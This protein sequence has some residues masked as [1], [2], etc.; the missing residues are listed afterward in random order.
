MNNQICFAACMLLLGC[1]DPGKIKP[2]NR[3]HTTS[4]SKA[5]I[6]KST[7]PIHYSDREL[8]AFLDSIGKL[9]T[10]PLVDKVAFYAD[11]VFLNQLPTSKTLSP[12]QFDL[13]QQAARTSV[14]SISSAQRIF[15]DVAIDSICNA[16]RIDLTYQKGLVPVVYYPFNREGFDEFALCIGDPEHCPNAVLYFFKGNKIIAKH[17]G[18][19][20]FFGLDLKHYKDSDGRTVV[21]YVHEFTEGSGVWWN[22]YFFYKYDGDTLLPILNELQ[23]GNLQSPWGFRIFWLES[24]IQKENPLTIKMVYYVQLPDT[25]KPDLGSRIIDDSTLVRYE[26]S[27][28]TKK[29]VARYQNSKITGSQVLS[30]Y[31][32]DNDLLFIN[33]YYKTLKKALRDTGQKRAT[34]NFLNEEKNYYRD[35]Q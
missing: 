14:I 17:D 25:T 3:N 7:N 11:S 29:L 16:S 13:V 23:N 20:R 2:I 31:V 10:Q 28:P 1:K 35:H 24:T 15:P 12:E 5:A 19:S 27:E 6:E 33:S 30:Y 34:L 32:E 18:Y 22:N 4:S 8:E 9:P 21:Y 26:T